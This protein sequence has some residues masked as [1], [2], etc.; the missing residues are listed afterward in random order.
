[1]IKLKIKLED[2]TNEENIPHVHVSLD[3]ISE[4]ELS[5]AT[6][7]EKLVLQV[8]HEKVQETLQNLTKNNE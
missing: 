6:E 2:I 5:K 1:M 3:K 8:V 4:K 7:N